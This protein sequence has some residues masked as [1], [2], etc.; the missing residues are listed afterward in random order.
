MGESRSPPP[1]MSVSRSLL[2]ANARSRSTNRDHDRPVAT[3][4]APTILD[5]RLGAIAIVVIFLSAETTL[6]LPCELTHSY[7]LSAARERKCARNGC[8]CLRTRL[9]A[10]SAGSV[11]NGAETL[12]QAGRQSFFIV[13]AC[14]FP[15]W[16]IRKPLLTCRSF[17]R[18]SAQPAADVNRNRRRWSKIAA[19]RRLYSRAHAHAIADRQGYTFI[20]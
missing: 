1:A 17:R 10:R 2:D 13:V 14:G 6:T 11:V 15:R 4:A 8:I 16:A 18:S 9:G 5:D 20:G 3:I 7:S 19:A 12:F